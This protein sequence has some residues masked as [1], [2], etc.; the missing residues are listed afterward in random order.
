[1]R[2]RRGRPARRQIGGHRRCRRSGTDRRGVGARLWRRRRRRGLRPGAARAPQPRRLRPW[3]GTVASAH[4]PAPP[5]QGAGRPLWSASGAPGRCR[6]A[7]GR[8]RRGRPRSRPVPTPSSMMGPGTSHGSKAAAGGGAGAPP[9][10]GGGGPPRWVALYGDIGTSPLYALPGVVRA[11]RAR[12]QPGTRLRRGVDRVLGADHHH[13]DQVP[14]ARDAGRQPRRGRH[15]RP[16][17]AADA[18]RSAG[19]RPAR[20][21]RS[22][23]SACSAP[24][25]STATA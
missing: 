17:R 8:P 15:P 5:A 14:A 18:P 21:G 3:V 2:L 20:S 10:R 16:H 13:L 11:R 9:G 23:A 7:G 19:C 24:R 12:G 22:S 25:C 1:M 4:H 6:W